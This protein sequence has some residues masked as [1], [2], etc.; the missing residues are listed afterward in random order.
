LHNPQQL[1]IKICS[2]LKKRLNLVLIAIEPAKAKQETDEARQN[3]TVNTSVNDS[4]MKVQFESFFDVMGH[5]I[6]YR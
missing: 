3:E 6:G 4:I 2:L 1:V 5:V